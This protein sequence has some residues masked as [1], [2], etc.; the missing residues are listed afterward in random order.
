M[1]AKTPKKKL[2]K[3]FT[4]NWYHGRAPFAILIRSSSKWT[5]SAWYQVMGL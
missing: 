5:R 1:P 2:I 3:L 4:S